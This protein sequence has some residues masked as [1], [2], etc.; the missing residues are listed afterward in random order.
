MIDFK[1]AVLQHLEAVLRLVVVQQN[2]YLLPM[3]TSDLNIQYL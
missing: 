3:L 2:L 1:G